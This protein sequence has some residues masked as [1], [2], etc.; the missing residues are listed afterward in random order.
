MSA[1]HAVQSTPEERFRTLVQQWKQGRGPTS[2]TTQ[3]AVHPAYQ[4]IIGM[5]GSAVPL[6]LR[7]LEREPDHWFCA[8]KAIT[9][10]DPVPEASR[11]RL[12]EM[13]DA[14]LK[15]GREHGLSW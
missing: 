12:R 14:W 2:S 8:L 7:E 9:G 6:L 13:T 10:E 1:T 5:G 15:W 11:G 3:L 4:Q